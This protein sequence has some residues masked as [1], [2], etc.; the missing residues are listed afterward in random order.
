MDFE[1]AFDS[2]WQHGLWTAMN[3][4]GSPNK[5]IKLLKALYNISQSAVRV[6]GDLTD[7]FATTVGVRQGCVLSPQLFNILLGVDDA[8][9]NKLR[10]WILVLTSRAVR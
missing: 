8:V 3:F 6:N 9:C 2:V 7:W 1:K 5:I 10:R 4:F